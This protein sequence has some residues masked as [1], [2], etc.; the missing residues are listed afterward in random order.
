MV[1]DV[2]LVDAAV[3][4]VLSGATFLQANITN[5]DTNVPSAPT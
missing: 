4:S 5:P 3:I 1:L 2:V